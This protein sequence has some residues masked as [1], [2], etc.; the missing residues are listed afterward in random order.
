MKNT[1]RISAML[2]SLVMLLCFL[3]ASVLAEIGDALNSEESEALSDLPVTDGDSAPYVL[4]EIADKRTET[5]KTFRMSDGSYIVADYGKRIHFEDENG[6]LQDYDNTLSASDVMTLDADDF[7]GAVNADSDVYVKLANNSNSNNLVKLQ[8]GDYKISLHLVGADKSKAIEIHTPEAE[9]TGNDIDSASTLHKF[10]SGAVYRD[11]LEGVDLEYIIYGGTVKENIIVKEQLDSY[12]FT[13]ELKLDGLDPVLQS[14]GSIALNDESGSAVM[15]IPKGVTYDANGNSSNAV[16]YAIS[17]KNGNKYTLTVTA[18]EEWIN[19]EDRAFPVTVDPTFKP[20]DNGANT[21]D[22]GIDSANTVSAY[23]ASYIRVGY[24]ESVRNM[25]LIRA[26]TL[27]VLPDSAVIVD[28]KL[29]LAKSS[30]SLGTTVA[31]YNLLNE[32]SST[33]LT[34]DTIPTN[35][36]IALDYHTIYAATAQPEYVFDITKAAQYWYEEDKNTGVMLAPYNA[37]GSGYINFKSSDSSNKPTITISYRDT[38]GLEGYWTYAAQS[39]GNAGVGYVNGFNG[40]LTFLHGDMSTEGSVIPVA[41]SHVY[42]GYQAGLEFTS[43]TDVNSPKTADYSNMLVGKGWKLSVQQ[44]VVEEII[45]S[46]TFY[47]YNDSDGTEHYF[48]QVNGIYVDEDGMGLTLTVND[49]GYV[50][51]NEYGNKYSFG[52]D[53]KITYITD[54][55]GNK[56]RFTY[57]DNGSLYAIYYQP[58]NGTL[59]QQLVFAYNDEG[60]LYRITN[61][62]NTN[63]YVHFLYSETIS[64]TPSINDSGYLREIR[65]YNGTTLLNSA[66]YEYYTYEGIESDGKTGAL[67]SARDGDTGYTLEYR[68]MKREGRFRAE[69]A[70]ESVNDTEGQRVGF[71]YEDKLFE[72][73][74]SG[75]NDIYDTTDDIYSYTLFDDYGLA[76]CSYSKLDGDTVPLGASYTEHM[77]Y[78]ATAETNYKVKTSAVKGITNNNLLYNP[79]CEP[80]SAWTKTVGGDGYSASY[81]TAQKY[82]GNGS[83]LLASVDGGTGFAM[84]S[85]SVYLTAGSYTLSAYVKLTNVSGTNGGFYLRC[86]NSGEY[87]TGTTNS[88]INNGWQRV[89][90]TFTVA[91][92]GNYDV[93]FGLEKCVGSA[94]VDC[95]MLEKGETPSDFNLIENGG[96]DRSSKWS[97]SYTLANGMA[98][99]TGSPTAQKRITQTVALNAPTNTTFM[100]SG[101]AKADSVDLSDETRKFGVIAKLTYSDNTTEEFELTFNPDNNN[102]QYASTAIVPNAEKTSV[103]SAEI[104]VAYDYNANVAYFGDISLTVEPAQTYT[105][106]SEGNLSTTTDVEGN[107]TVMEY[108]E[109]GVD[110]KDYTAITGESF[111]YTYNS[112]HQVTSV[113]KTVGD[114]TQTADYEYDRYGNTTSVALSASGSNLKITSSAAYSADGNY[115]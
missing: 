76:I 67:K 50:I 106:D 97:G 111:E 98:K 69:L 27:P 75:S 64:G 73:R 107:E 7:V 8:K 23:D 101:W 31:A 95:A 96:F 39:A 109:N 2:L 104:T 6:N 59:V 25:L 87:V 44:T 71:S 43:G 77:P 80:S 24:T 55:N 19:A 51:E 66:Y 78:D 70:L 17:H 99:L 9:P 28:A 103:T 54:V 65:Y 14:D 83:L 100:L 79:N 36:T 53:G 113:T 105:Y 32:W 15:V 35:S 18:D 12:T 30:V 20:A 108:H 93:V 114:S 91:A 37:S 41:V 26:K 10:S 85:D 5:T 61:A 72:T 86:V 52:T 34:S 13:F 63:D 47:V 29:K 21:E 16:E 46:E 4:G 45:D 89:S 74:T 58:V 88:A 40:N 22:I 57:N 84:Y 42:N 90:H 1:T 33:T 3:P 48:V 115:L 62:Y 11:I 60:A 94:Y 110:L 82:M 92:A 49:D 112:R 56:K 102:K 81:S 68:Y 38:K